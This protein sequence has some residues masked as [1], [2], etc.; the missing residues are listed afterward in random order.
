MELQELYN[1]LKAEIT[2]GILKINGQ[3]A[4]MTFLH[5]ILALQNGELKITNTEIFLLSG[6]IKIQGECSLNGWAGGSLFRVHI[7]CMKEEADFKLEVS[8]RSSYRGSLGGFFREVSPCLKRD[9]DG[10]N[11]ESSVIA[12]FPISNPQ[13]SFVTS[14]Y[15][16]L[17]PFTFQ[18]ETQMRDLKGW[19]PYGF[20]FAGNQVVSGRTNY[21]EEFQLRVPVAGAISGFFS[22][23]HMMLLLFNR[24]EYEESVFYPYISEA[25]LE[26]KLQLDKLPEATFS[27]PLFTQSKRWN[28]NMYVRDGFGVGDL[29]SF[30]MYITKMGEE[31][32]SLCLPAGVDLNKFRLYRMNILSE[33]EKLK[34][35]PI[36]MTMEFALSE[37][38]VLSIPYVTLE[39]LNAG[40]QVSLGN[41]CSEALPASSLFTA[42]AGGT[43]AFQIGNYKLALSLDMMFPEMDF[44]ASVTLSEKTGEDAPR[45]SDLAQTFGAPLPSG[46]ESEENVLGEVSVSGSAMSRDINIHAEVQDILAFSVGTLNIALTKLSAD[47]QVST[48]HFEFAVQGIMTFGSGVDEFVLSAKAAYKNPGWMLEGKLQSGEVNIGH[49]LAE[50]FDIQTTP[51][52]ISGLYL[53]E[54][55]TSYF[56]LEERFSLTAAFEARWQ[57]VLLGQNLVLGGRIEVLA[58]PDKDTDVSA[59]AFM[60]L[61]GFHVLVQVDHIQTAAQRSYLFRLQYKE[62]YLQAAWFLRNEDEILSVSLGGM[63]LGS[64]V[65][66]LI[67]MINPNHKYGLASPWDILERI[68]LEKFMLEFNVTRNEALILYRAQMDI[69]GLMYLDKVG[70]RYD[71]GQNKLYFILTGKILGVEYGENDP[72]TWDAINGRP[73]VNVAED[74]K[75]FELSYLGLGQHVHVEG[76]LAAESIKEA[77]QTLKEQLVPGE[78]GEAPEEITCDSTINWLFGIDFTVNSSV[79]VKL[80]MNDPVLYGVLITVQAKKGSALEAFDGFG[81][82]LLYK[83][84]TDTVGMFKGEVLVPKRYRTFQLGV[85]TL[86]LGTVSLE[87]YTNGGFYLDLG[88]PHQQDFS[89]SFQFQWSIY[90]G[91][92]GIYLGVLK[93]VPKLTVPR[94]INGNF[95]PILMLGIGMR[96]GMGR[97]FDFG[98]VSGGVSLEVFGILE[99][100]VAVFHEKNTEKEDTYYYVKAVAGISGRLFLSADLKIIAIHASVEVNASAAITIQAYRETLIELELSLTLKASFKIFFIKI[101]F[102]F[103]FHQKLQFSI[104]KN[105]RTPWIEESVNRKLHT[106]GRCMPVYLRTQKLKKRTLFLKMIPV[107]VLERPSIQGKNERND[108]MVLLMV[109]NEEDLR[110]W[111][112]LLTEWLLS[113]FEGTSLTWEEAGQLS[114]AFADQLTWNLLNQFLSENVWIDYNIDWE[115]KDQEEM[116]EGYVFPMLPSVTVCVS[117][118]GQEHT[119]NY[120]E[121]QMVDED[122]FDSITGYFEKLNADPSYQPER[123]RKAADGNELQPAAKAFLTDYVQ[124]YLRELAGQV[125]QLY[126]EYRGNVGIRSARDDF[127]I[128]PEVFVLQN[129]ELL[130][131]TGRQIVFDTLVYTVMDGDTLDVIGNRYGLGTEELWTAVKDTLSLP[132]VGSRMTFGKGIFVNKRTGLTLKEVAAVLFVRFYESDC[133]ED[134]FYAGDILQMNPQISMQWQETVPYGNTLVLPETAHK[135][136]TLRGDTAQRLGAFLF[137]MEAKSGEVPAWDQ[138]LSKIS[139]LNAEK[140]QAVLEEVRF[141][142]PEVE[143]YRDCTLSELADRIYPDKTEKETQAGHLASSRILRPNIQLI[144]TGATFFTPTERELSL[145]DIMRESGCSAEELSDVL[146]ADEI[147]VKKQE[148][149]IWEAEVIQKEHIQMKIQERAVETGSMLSRFLLQG[150]KVPEPKTKE[151]SPLYQILGQQIPVWDVGHDIRLKAASVEKSCE[152]VA[153]EEKE[154]VL[155]A[156]K[157]AGQLPSGDFSGFP[158]SWEQA[159]DFQDSDQFF[160]LDQSMLYENKKSKQAIH[161]LSEAVAEIIVESVEPVVVDQKGNR[162]AV[163]W[164]CMIPIEI[165]KTDTESV[166]SVYG[167]DTVRRQWLHEILELED[168]DVR[169]LY[170]TSGLGGESKCF[171]EYDWS[172][173]R[174]FLVKTNFSVETHIGPVKRIQTSE[175]VLENIVRTGQSQKLVRMLWECSTVGGGGYYLHLLTDDRKT[176]PSDL[177]DKEGNGTIWILVLLRQYTPKTAYINCCVSETA[178][179]VID[180]LTLITQDPSQKIRNACYPAGCIGVRSER[181]APEDE[182][183]SSYA[184]MQRLYQIVGYQIRGK[185]GVYEESG[186]SAP[187][188]PVERGQIWV[189][190][191]V[192]PLYKYALAVTDSA[193]PY[194]AVGK[195]AAISMEL[196]DIFGNSVEAGNSS[197]QP[198]Y[199][200]VM[201]GLSE[202]AQTRLYCRI[203]PDGDAAYLHIYVEFSA[204]G[205]ISDEAAIR[206]RFAAWQLSCED[207]EITIASPVND[208]F[209]NLSECFVAG[210]TYL[211]LVCRYA[212]E[213]A[214]YMEGSR[215]EI[216]KDLDLPFALELEQYP[217]EDH[218]FEVYT[219]AVITRSVQ[220]APDPAS[221]KAVSHILPYSVM[222]DE[223]PFQTFCEE[224]QKACPSLLFAQDGSCAV[225]YGVTTGSNGFLKACS[226]TPK[227]YMLP[228]DLGKEREEVVTAPE[229]YALRPLHHG[230]V[231][232]TA[233]IRTVM[234]D[235]AIEEKVYDL[236]FS[237]VDMEVWAVQ[238]LRDFEELFTPD[239]VQRAGVVCAS[240]FDGILNVKK[241]LAEAISWQIAAL[242]KEAGDVPV[243]VRIRAEDYLRRSLIDGYDMDVAA[244]YDLELKAVDRCRLTAEVD[245]R[246]GDCLITAGKADTEKEE[247]F[248]FVTNHFQENTR[249]LHADLVFTELEYDIKTDR[250]YESSRWLKFITPFKP[251]VSG[252]GRT[253]LESQVHLPNPFKNCPQIPVFHEHTC[254]FT[255]ADRK[256]LNWDYEF[257]FNCRYAMQDTIQIR[258]EFEPMANLKTRSIKRDLFDLLAEYIQGR[259]QLMTCLKS[260]DD[261]VYQNAFGSL[262]TMSQEMAEAWKTWNQTMYNRVRTGQRQTYSEKLSYSCIVRGE[263]DQTGLQFWIE[264]TEEGRIFLEQTGALVPEI[265]SDENAVLPDGSY[266]LKFSFKKLPL[267]QCAR[268]IPY[269]SLVRNQNLLYNKAEKNYLEVTEEFVY[270]TPEI[271]FLPLKASGCIME[272][273][274]IGTIS[275][276]RFGESVIRQMVD[277][278][279]ELFGLT[280]ERILIELGVSYYYG[281]EEGQKE[282]RIVLPVTFVPLTETFS[283]EGAYAQFGERL[284]QN[285]TD[286]FNKKQPETNCC[287]FLFHLKVYE[288]K[289]R[290]QILYFP[291]LNINFIKEEYC[292]GYCSFRSQ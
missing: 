224:A 174:S 227:H 240:Q 137:L 59:L 51:E 130:V 163:T 258:I 20:L 232:R 47:T 221:Q 112:G 260:A 29:L 160:R 102:S 142:V 123:G 157:I 251:D 101:R 128:S 261:M 155:E 87:V 96:V 234:A 217:L 197:V 181:P 8:F 200:D 274:V 171:M 169:I 109:M 152:W 237:D 145:A 225:L 270:R 189:Y 269:I 134:L 140:E 250:G 231:T 107:F 279:L 239:H 52:D 165:S 61:G 156:D 135:W 230:F 139:R 97:S 208:R 284:K 291:K 154:I 195:P 198:Y 272:E 63:T 278:L 113:H 177:F 7:L 214:A 215:K 5:F 172:E 115:Q 24:V 92:G 129:Q 275:S 48:T 254:R 191:P 162:Q 265:L 72:V 9:E 245:N 186:M 277:L 148:A 45:L 30:L 121:H 244:C 228:S 73:P 241:K 126:R 236:E 190:E 85:L 114:S 263:K 168:L 213:L 185:E 133:P 223:R 205:Q 14:D 54:L 83:K 282:P 176:L 259:Q 218:I 116:W 60:N 289:T 255:L 4:E 66:S 147:L 1:I 37:P 42:E 81:I 57:I 64:L 292:T 178:T 143:V 204:E 6:S 104:G 100:V 39:R 19:E 167:A 288:P 268:A 219:T 55:S 69:A 90:N 173:S 38:W 70:L 99:G 76:V 161:Q 108:A 153:R 285:I 22:S 201:I 276:D 88:F 86:T 199:N 202:W 179:H 67:Q 32:V 95:S 175:P 68:N 290:E 170:Q 120:W 262:L 193:N 149:V 136:I 283:L 10:R 271:S 280:K 150:L 25:G 273:I 256:T 33:R 78:A 141:E 94:I 103:T 287:G 82:E 105:E 188:I 158:V 124:M 159:A 56:T 242:R 3:I 62:V 151:M 286:W 229:F 53:T 110:Q 248:L 246:T 40:I 266:M 49:L 15:D 93:D 80:V 203:L 11:K 75:T 26:I 27:V 216:P 17:L 125:G 18:A 211:E 194:G 192:I 253:V 34:L 79:N 31:S 43:L 212:E 21:E 98:I 144:L 23:L 84:I 166:F 89:R 118:Q 180:G 71:I 111:N 187:V 252:I 235:G 46:W 77:M 247:F 267:Y 207:V 257:I 146:L 196:R 281:L 2:N 182:D 74:E 91:K 233:K 210:W 50:M 209:W 127:R 13:I 238:F 183:D 222:S 58:L 16:R 106:G 117:E 36:Y 138:F 226:V 164:G 122:Y 184:L 35:T 44:S 206:Q 28:L 12:D 41:Q 264:S 249:D 132:Y 220:L 119:I 65:E 131:Q 243:D